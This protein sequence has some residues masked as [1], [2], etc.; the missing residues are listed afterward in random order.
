MHELSLVIFVKFCHLAV[1]K[2]VPYNTE[3]RLLWTG[4]YKL[5]W[6]PPVALTSAV[7]TR[8]WSHP[9]EQISWPFRVLL[10]RPAVLLLKFLY[11]PSHLSLALIQASQDIGAK[12]HGLHLGLQGDH[13]GQRVLYNPIAMIWIGVECFPKQC[14]SIVAKDRNKF[15]AKFFN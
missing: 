8:F 2:F 1:T 15:L 9:I 14:L 4:L 10:G 6:G 11:C 3:L 5:E 13:L 12:L 7:P